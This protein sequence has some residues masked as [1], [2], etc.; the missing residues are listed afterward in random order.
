MKF[1]S[2]KPHLIVLATV[3]V[4]VVVALMIV[5]FKTDPKDGALKASLGFGSKKTPSAPVI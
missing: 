1:S 4:G 2:L 3:I 5:K